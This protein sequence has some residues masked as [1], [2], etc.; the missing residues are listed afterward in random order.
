MERFT[1]GFLPIALH[2]VVLRPMRIWNRIRDGWNFI[3]SFIVSPEFREQWFL[4]EIA[5]GEK[6]GMLTA[7]ERAGL[8]AVVKD[9]FIVRYLKCVG[10]HFAT[11]PVTQIVS[12]LLGAIWAI[13]L[14]TKGHSWE[15]ALGAFG[16]TVAVF[17]VI[18]ISPGSI[19]RGGFVVYLMIKERNVR[20]Y[21]IAAPVSFMKYIGYLAYRAGQIELRLARLAYSRVG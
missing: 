18:P 7:E 3:H 1:I 15:E 4:N 13:W 17:Q 8:E 16:L 2:R 10:V 5:L 14:I 11:L 12:V 9:P 19:C 6:D 21:I 20:D